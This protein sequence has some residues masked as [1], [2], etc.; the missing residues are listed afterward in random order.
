[1][2]TT[3]LRSQKRPQDVNHPVVYMTLIVFKREPEPMTPSR[4]TKLF[5]Y[6]LDDKKY[7]NVEKS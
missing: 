7:K 3:K 4:R 1:M 5:S 2:V 6:Y